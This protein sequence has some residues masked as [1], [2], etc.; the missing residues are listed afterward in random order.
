VNGDTI[1]IPRSAVR[2]LGTAVLGLASLAILGLVLVTLVHE[3]SP[4]DTLATAIDPHSY[5]AVFLSN[6]QVYFGDLSAPGGDTYYLRHVFY[7]SSQASPQSG[8]S[9]AL[10]LIRLTSAVHSPQD[11]M[12]IPRSQILFI[13]N[14]KPNGKVAKYIRSAGSSP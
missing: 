13:E 2:H 8:R 1:A 4:R 9:A 12:V 5:Q 11:L 7:L 14:L 6:G 3:F 10:T